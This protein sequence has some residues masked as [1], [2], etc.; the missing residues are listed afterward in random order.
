M[1]QTVNRK[2][3]A[4]WPSSFVRWAS[5][6]VWLLLFFG[7]LITVGSPNRQFP[8]ALGWVMLAI[9]AA[10]LV[11][12]MSYWVHLLPVLFGY[13]ALNGLLSIVNGH[14]GTDASRPISRVHAVMMTACFIGCALLTIRFRRPVTLADRLG[15]LGAFAAVVFGV[16]DERA[17]VSACILMFMS[18]LAAV[19]F[20]VL[21]FGAL[22]GRVLL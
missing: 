20:D 6:A 17:S 21:R 3:F 14:L 16:F 12:T 5:F 10:V 2:L 4:G 9:A 11:M 18:V 7:A 1:K 13:G 8:V 22:K 19:L 15:L